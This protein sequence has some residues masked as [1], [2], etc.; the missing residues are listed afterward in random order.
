MRPFMT[1]HTILEVECSGEGLPADTDLTS[2]A[3]YSADDDVDHHVIASVNLVHDRCLCASGF[4]ACHLDRG[5]SRRTRLRVLVQDLA[6]GDSRVYGCDVSTFKPGER[7]Q[8]VSWKLRV[9]HPRELT[10]H[11]ASGLGAAAEAVTEC[12]VVCV[13][14]EGREDILVN[15]R[16]LS[17][18]I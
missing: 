1:S 8:F 18:Y 17:R 14:G 15:P 4:A 10:P 16:L 9:Q 12:E 5:D 13:G 2:I 7:P 6:R 3:L 11:L